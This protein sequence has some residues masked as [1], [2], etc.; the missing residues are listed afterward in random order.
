MKRQF[1]FGLIITTL[2]FI[3]LSKSI[4]G[5]EWTEP[6]NINNLGGY[7]L[8]PDMAI[9]HSGVIHLVWSQK[10]SSN[11]WL[12]LYAKSADDGL[13]WSE[14][15]DLLCNTELVMEQPRIACNSKNK[16][17]VTY[18]HDGNGI[19]PGGRLIKMLTWDGSQWS[20]PITVSVGMTGS[21][22]GSIAINQKDKLYIFWLI[23]SQ[24]G[25]I[26]M[27]YSYNDN[28]GWGNI[29]CPYCDSTF[30]HLPA[31]YSIE[32][33]I[34]HWSGV[35]QEFGIEKPEYFLFK[36]DVNCWE[37]PEVISNDTIIVDIDIAL[38]NQS[39]PE[40]AYR[41]I[42]SIPPGFGFEGTMHTKKDG[43]NWLPPEIVSGTDKRQEGQQI[44]IDQNNNINVLETQYYVS[45]EHETELIHY[46]NI[47]NTWFSHPIDYSDNLCNMPKLLFSKNKLYVVYVWSSHE[48]NQQYIRF[49]KY[50]VL[51][52]INGEIPGE[53]ELKIYPNPGANNIFIEFEPSARFARRASPGDN[54]KH[55]NINLSVFDMSGK[56]IKTLC[57]KTLP[58]ERQRLLWNGTD[59]SGKEVQ[60]GS[61][62]V[63]LK[64][65][66]KT[67][68]QI[69]EVVK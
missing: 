49:S 30:G 26:D 55:Q 38:N 9:D 62:L 21:H 23:G 50:D 20:E 10:V 68:T 32:D 48:L 13:T 56:L 25:S 22:Y 46:Y 16:L 24:M 43:S 19:T 59:Q 5:Q 18:T 40:T 44:A 61:Y 60:S 33:S 63:R 36:T 2:L 67:I 52:N 45:N 47:E 41:K 8:N 37:F 58:P 39:I 64:T 3:S 42:S 34:M 15:L 35:Y 53:T 31:R 7:L 69:V 66:G 29:F 28:N 65:G 27:Y 17:Y 54:T 6:V 12:I 14:P 11:H 4:S 57:N 1:F 51:T